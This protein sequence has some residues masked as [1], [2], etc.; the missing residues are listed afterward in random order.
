MRRW[1]SLWGP[2]LAWMAFISYASAQSDTGR[3][4]RVPDWA[5]HGA[6]YFLLGL[7]LCRTIVESHGG[8]VTARPNHPRGAVFEITLPVRHQPEGS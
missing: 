5:T 2:P 1:V 6:A 3:L 4:G 7:L 8:R